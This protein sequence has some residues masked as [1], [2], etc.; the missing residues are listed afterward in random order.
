MNS[1]TFRSRIVDAL[2]TPI[3]FRMTYR[4][5]L[6]EYVMVISVILLLLHLIVPEWVAAREAAR[7][8]TCKNGLKQLPLALHNSDEMSQALPATSEVSG[9]RLP[10][11]QLENWLDQILP[12]PDAPAG[13][14]SG[15]GSGQPC[16]NESQ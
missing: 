13:L 4:I 9:A 2:S 15:T 5:I 6:V 16:G 3:E 14:S 10:S 7:R 12:R 1:S 8:S 11:G